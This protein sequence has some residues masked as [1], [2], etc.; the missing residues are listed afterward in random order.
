MIMLHPHTQSLGHWVHIKEACTASYVYVLH[1]L[2]NTLN[3]YWH[4][5]FF[6]Y[7]FKAHNYAYNKK[8]KLSISSRF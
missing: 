4:F 8:N 6:R 1:K 2:L 3:N 5:I 7:N